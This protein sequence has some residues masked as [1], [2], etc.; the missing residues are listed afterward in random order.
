MDI[1]TVYSFHEI[2]GGGQ[3]GTV[4][5]GQRKN[6]NQIKKYAIKTITKKKLSSRDIQNLTNEVQI[7]SSLD[8]PN[9]V[10][11]EELKTTKNHYYIVK[12]YYVKREFIYNM[13]TQ[14]DIPQ[15]KINTRYLLDINGF[16]ED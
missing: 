5:V 13:V 3:F 12:E 16:V 11:L 4:R 10:R 9:I 15:S 2:L 8:H 7:L 6:G 1:K 14:K